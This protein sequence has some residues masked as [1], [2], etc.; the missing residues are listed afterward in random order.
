MF[1]EIL[2]ITL[3]IYL[4]QN[5]QLPSI[6]LNLRRLQ[7]QFSKNENI[8]QQGNLLTDFYKKFFFSKKK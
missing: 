3:G 6:T 2:L 1:Y 4:E 5:Y 7:I 8:N